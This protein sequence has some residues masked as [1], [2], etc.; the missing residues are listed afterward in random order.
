MSFF[1]NSIRK[2]EKFLSTVADS[3]YPTHPLE[4]CHGDAQIRQSI[5]NNNSNAVLRNLNQ[6]NDS[7]FNNNVP[8][9]PPDDIRASIDLCIKYYRDL[10]SSLQ[11]QIKILG[12]IPDIPNDMKECLMI[13]LEQELQSEISV[14]EAI[15]QVNKNEKDEVNAKIMEES[16]IHLEQMKIIRGEAEDASVDAASRSVFILL[17]QHFSQLEDSVPQWK[18]MILQF[19]IMKK[20]TPETLALIASDRDTEFSNVHETLKSETHESNHRGW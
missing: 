5:P 6:D 9:V 13:Y 3:L 12:I 8:L 19:M 10:L 20:I 15:Q 16:K 11:E 7:I 18:N 14:R 1:N 2:V 17:D 4:T